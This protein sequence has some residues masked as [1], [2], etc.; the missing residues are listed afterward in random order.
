LGTFGLFVDLDAE[1]HL[2]FSQEDRDAHSSRTSSRCDISS[3][4]PSGW[5]DWS[6]P[7]DLHG[8]RPVGSW[9]QFSLEERIDATRQCVL[10]A[11]AKR[12]HEFRS[13][14]SGMRRLAKCPLSV[15]AGMMGT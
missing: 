11:L 12:T 10:N 2:S 4:M 7:D 14:S 15:T 1:G 13:P 9:K 6:Q 5:D 8:N 3:I